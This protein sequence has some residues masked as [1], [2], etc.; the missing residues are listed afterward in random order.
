MSCVEGK[1]FVFLQEIQ[2]NPVN[3]IITLF[4]NLEEKTD[5]FSNILSPGTTA[6]M[7]TTRISMDYPFP[8]Y[9]ELSKDE[10]ST[11]IIVK[12]ELPNDDVSLIF[13]LEP[14][15]NTNKQD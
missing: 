15:S 1:D 3:I 12:T 11:E 13:P 14:Q 4:A 2:K 5:S 6:T 9:D 8:E 7:R 10:D